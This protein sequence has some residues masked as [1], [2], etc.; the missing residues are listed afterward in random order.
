MRTI[1][2]AVFWVVGIVVVVTGA[3]IW[4][5]VYRPLPQLD[6]NAVLPG[7]QKEVTVERDAWGVPHI[8]ASSVEDLAEAQGYVMAQDRLWQMDLLRRVARGQLSEILGKS[9]LAIDKDFRTMEFG[10][11]ADREL[12]LM[13]KDSR[14][15]MEAFARGVNRDDVYQGAEE[16]G[17]PVEEHIS[18]CIQ[19]LRGSAQ[20]L[21]LA[22]AA[23]L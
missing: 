5:L 14:D 15:I 16:M 3:A 1:L 10:R 7:L 12:G 8:R 21:G 17:V 2:R 4:W 22:G 11:T 19:A 20:E 18:F 9:T 13:D 6:G 23:A